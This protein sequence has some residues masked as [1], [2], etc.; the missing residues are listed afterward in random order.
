MQKED[1]GIMKKVISI[2][3]LAVLILSACSNDENNAEQHEEKNAQRETKDDVALEGENRYPLTGLYTNDAVDN[4]IF[5]VMINNHSQARPQSGLSQ[6]DIVFEILAE[7]NITRFL[8]LYQSE[9]PEKIGP[10]RSAREYYFELA[11]RYNALYV[12]HG[13][14][15]FV[16][17]MIVN[18][19]TEFLN[20]AIHDNDGVLFL[21]ESF[22]QAPHNS[23]LLSDA[24]YGA[25]NDKGYATEMAYEPLPFLEDGEMDE[26]EGDRADHI[27]I[28]YSDQPMEIVEYLYNP[29]LKS[30]QRFSDQAE[31]V[32]YETGDPVMVENIFIIETHHEVIDDQGRRRI[33]LDTGGNAYLI[34]HGVAQQVQWENDNG[35]L[36]PVKDGEAVG[37][38]PG[39]TWINVIPT[40]PSMEE[41][42]TIS[43]DREE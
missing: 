31:T 25:A 10:V 16:D 34:Q 41:S 18:Q 22:R 11:N 28:V 39:K 35:R 26:L 21:R 5:G 8:A 20:G 7:A 15:E 29:E 43:A 6:A 13:A 9:I 1:V 2:F 12:Y 30:Y 4:R 36:I 3:M 27:E 24:V 14:A 17:D 38:M 23:Y 19:G 33:D 42:V 37:F 40:S 32:E